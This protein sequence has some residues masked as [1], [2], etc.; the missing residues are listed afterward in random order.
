[1]AG[2]ATPGAGAIAEYQI[3]TLAHSMPTQYTDPE[4]TFIYLRARYYDP[5]TAQFLTPDP[6]FAITG[7]RYGYA[8]NDPINYD[9]P[10]GLCSWTSWSCDQQSVANVA[11]GVLNGITLGHAKGVLNHVPGTGSNNADK[12]NWNS[13]GARDG[14]SVGVGLDAVGAAWGAAAG[15]GWLAV[16]ADVSV[17]MMLGVIGVVTPIGVGLFGSLGLSIYQAIS[18]S[19]SCG[20]N[21][22]IHRLNSINSPGNEGN[23]PGTPEIHSGGSYPIPER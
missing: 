16:T 6:L 18:G 2:G 11:G 9:D 20:L 23:D 3:A 19:K 21:T 8:G 15:V 7:S 12:V 13:R 4:T 5:T 1:M 10:L 22:T 14:H 17:P